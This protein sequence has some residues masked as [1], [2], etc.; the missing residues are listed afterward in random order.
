MKKEALLLHYPRT[1]SVCLSVRAGVS[2]ASF[3]LGRHFPSFLLD[4]V[5]S[6]CISFPLVGPLSRRLSATSALPVHLRL[7]LNGGWSTCAQTPI[8]TRTDFVISRTSLSRHRDETSDA[9]I[10]TDPSVYSHRTCAHNRTRSYS[11]AGN[12]WRRV[13]ES[14]TFGRPH[15]F[16]TVV[17]PMDWSGWMGQ[18]ALSV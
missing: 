15:L 5:T 11:V 6:N 14:T 18:S 17:A 8:L 9:H 4:L 2:V 12:D 13:L 3:L 10:H 16:F 1:Q 7:H